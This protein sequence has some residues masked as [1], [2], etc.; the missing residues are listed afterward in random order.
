[1]VDEVRDRNALGELQHAAD[2]I[3]VVVRR[4][5]KVDLLQPR[6]VDRRHDPIAVAVAGIA[7]VDKQ[8]LPGRRDPQ[9][10]LPPFGVDDVHLERL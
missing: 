7:A 3:D 6:I 2:V 1:V 10:R 9:C 5:Q 8:R 4:D